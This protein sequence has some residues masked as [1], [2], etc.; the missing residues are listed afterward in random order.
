MTIDMDIYKP[1][2]DEMKQVD[3]TLGDKP[4]QSRQMIDYLNNRTNKYFEELQLTNKTQLINI[5]KNMILKKTLYRVMQNIQALYQ[6][7]SN[8]PI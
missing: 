7:I 3:S 4:T 5:P 8:H 6:M 2:M 1:S